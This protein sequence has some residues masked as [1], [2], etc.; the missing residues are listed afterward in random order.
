M[1]FNAGE[2]ASGSGTNAIELTDLIV[3]IAAGAMLVWAA[4]VITSAFRAWMDGSSNFY[5]FMWSSLRAAAVISIL[6]FFIRPDS[7]GSTTFSSIVES[8]LREI[9][10]VM[11]L[12]VS[13]VGMV[14]FAWGA[15]AKFNEARTGR[16]EWGEV[17]LLGIVGA[18]MLM[19]VGYLL[20]QAATVFP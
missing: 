10:L 9:G 12:F 8:H 3:A 13:V 2:F 4:W 19:F 5:D 7:N 18:A 11:G 20:H 14:W 6:G 16:A 17:G 15:I 1:A